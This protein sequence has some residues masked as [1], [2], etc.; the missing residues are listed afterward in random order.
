MPARLRPVP[1]RL[2][3]DRVLE[4]LRLTAGELGVEAYLV[5]GFVRDRLL[6]RGEFAQEPSK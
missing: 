5:G 1:P 3:I 6:G 2:D 4:L